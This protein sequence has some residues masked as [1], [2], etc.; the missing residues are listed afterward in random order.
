MATCAYSSERSSLLLLRYVKQKCDL[1]RKNLVNRLR[2]WTRPIHPTWLLSGGVVDATSTRAELIAENMLLRH[3]LIVLQ[4]QVK[5]PKLTWRERIM[6]VLLAGW[7]GECWRAAVMIAKP[8]T[9]LRWHRD[10]YRLVWRRKAKAKG[11][12]GRPPLAL[13]K[14]NLIR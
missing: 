14:V 1:Q 6:I 12:G 8:E 9:V 3:Q 7:M 5:R 13:E 2:N 4:R 10:I 11:K